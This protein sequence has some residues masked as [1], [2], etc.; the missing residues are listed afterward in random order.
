MIDNR[1]NNKW[2][3]YI[4]ISPNNKYYVGITSQEL[5]RRWGINGIRYKFHEK[6]YNS[7]LKYGW[8]NFEHE[9]IADNLTEKEACG[10]EIMLIK[11]LESTTNKGFNISKGGLGGNRKETIKVKQYTLSGEYLKT[12]NSAS[13]AGLE[14]GI[15]RTRI[16]NCCKKKS[17][18][19]CGYMWS[20][21]SDIINY[22]Y[23][24]KNQMDIYQ[25][26]KNMNFIKKWDSIKQASDCLKI[27][28][29]SISKCI[30]MKNKFAYGFIFRYDLI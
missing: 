10:M 20:Y 8:D 27:P 19:A 14:V 23:K 9:L 26:D 6:F 28:V 17:N 15:D 22:K 25:Y 13:E 29:V 11:L 7:I 24:R 5:K 3:V 16:T 4:H 12:F 30:T 18:M 2:K 1:I 21:E